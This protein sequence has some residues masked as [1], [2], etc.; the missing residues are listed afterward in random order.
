MVD[1]KTVSI[2]LRDKYGAEKTRTLIDKENLDKV[3]KK[4]N[5][6]VYYKNNEQPFAISNTPKGRIYLDKFIM[7]TPENMIVHHI[8][9]NT[10]DNRKSNLENKALS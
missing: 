8:N 7:D 10:L 6:W 3:L 1:E 4:T 2:I 5:G 9:L